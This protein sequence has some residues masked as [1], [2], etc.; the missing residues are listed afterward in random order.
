M[1]EKDYILGLFPEINQIK[2]EDIRDKTIEVWRRVW[3]QSNWDKIEDC[4]YNPM[5]PIKI[6][7]LVNHI[8]VVTRGCIELAEVAKEIHRVEINLD[9]LIASS[10]LHDVCKLLEYEIKDGKVSKTEI[11]E[12]FVHG[13]YGSKTA[14]EVGLDHNIA[15]LIGIHTAGSVLPPKPPVV[16]EGTILHLVDMIDTDFLRSLADAPLIYKLSL[17][18]IAHGNR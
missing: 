14:L 16:R 13:F 3:K 10:I 11:G 2:D 15:H 12:K 17:T 7:N 5:I 4:I 6:S 9:Y 1:T 8:R 18:K